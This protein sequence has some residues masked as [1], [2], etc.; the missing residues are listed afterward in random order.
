MRASGAHASS[1]TAFDLTCRSPHTLP[2]S[3][4][5]P[6]SSS[7]LIDFQPRCFSAEQYQVGPARRLTRP[8]QCLLCLPVPDVHQHDNHVCFSS[9]VD[10]FLPRMSCAGAGPPGG[11]GGEGGGA[12]GNAEVAPAGAGGGQGRHAPTRP[13][14]RLL[15]G[16]AAPELRGGAGAARQRCATTVAFM[17]RDALGACPPIF[18]QK[19]VSADRCMPALQ[20]S[21]TCQPSVPHP[22]PLHRLCR[23]FPAV[24]R[25]AGGLACDLR[26]PRCRR[27]AGRP[28]RAG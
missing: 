27:A 23:G 26:Q 11:A 25:S 24:R 5:P 12:R 7:C 14:P 19:R 15:L 17:Y 2:P 21:R 1:A 13:W 28:G 8:R 10:C 18:R 4:P 9:L 6:A 16:W 3:F 20:L 22:P